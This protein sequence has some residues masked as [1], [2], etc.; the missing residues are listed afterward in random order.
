MRQSTVLSL[1]AAATAVAMTIAAPTAEAQGYPTRPVRIIVGFAPGGSTDLAGRMM[2][3]WLGDRLGKQ[4]VIENRSGAA[5][6]I[7]AESAARAAPDGHT[8]L[9]VSSTDT[10][11]ATLHPKAGFNFL[12]EIAA[13]AGLTQQPQVLLV[14]PAV[15]ATTFSELIAHLNRIVHELQARPATSAGSRTIAAVLLPASDKPVARIPARGAGRAPPV[16]LHRGFA[17]TR[18]RRSA[19]LR[20]RALPPM[21]EGSLQRGR[22]ACILR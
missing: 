5:S 19:K 1:I 10:I 7:A 16:D 22:P 9:M 6:H 15:P 20:A 3:Q 4:F 11:N 14:N 12:Q 13:V 2:G 21:P 17:L 18:P 8:L